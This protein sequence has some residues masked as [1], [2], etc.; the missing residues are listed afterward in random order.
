MPKIPGY[1]QDLQ[2]EIR[3]PYETADASVGKIR[4]Q[5]IQNFA[6]GLQDLGQGLQRQEAFDEAKRKEAENV[7]LATFGSAAKGLSDEIAF[8]ASSK[9]NPDGND[10]VKLYSDEY[11]KKMTAEM[12]NIKD[13]LTQQKAYT[14]YQEIKNDRLEKLRA[15]SERMFKDN[16][17][18]TYENQMK[19]GVSRV[20][21]NP[22]LIDKELEDYANTLMKSGYSQENKLKAFNLGKEQMTS[23]AL[24][25]YI[26]SGD[27][28]GAK[29]ALQNKFVG[30]FDAEKNQAWIDKIDNERIKSIDSSIKSA[31]REEKNFADALSQRQ[32]MNFRS[33]YGEISDLSKVDPYAPGKGQSAEKIITK[34]DDMVSSGDLKA[35]EAE[36]LKRFLSNDKSEDSAAVSLDFY[37]KLASGA[38]PDSLRKD[39]L[40]ASTANQISPQTAQT[41]LGR[42]ENE[43]QKQAAK[44]RASR[45]R[46]QDPLKKE[47]SDLIGAYF[48]PNPVLGGRDASSLQESE[49]D[50]KAAWYKIME[51]PKY[52]NDPVGAAR[53][54]LQMKVPGYVPATFKNEKE[55]IDL[56]K[57]LKTQYSSGQISKT[58]YAS[59]IQDLAKKRRDFMLGGK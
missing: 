43:K 6:S 40:T 46:R 5:A 53:K 17:N 27:Y 54:A 32:D 4:S 49:A 19:V 16:A 12:K 44:G 30:V 7:Q 57:N 9:A 10:L 35:P 48:K 25:G 34:I 2:R 39:I 38:N 42:I 51:N 15:D 1:R 21:S 24:N 37:N 55:I 23:A 29:S 28:A 20:S 59:K 33:V 26:N 8:N 22:T 56:S 18:I 47:A 31:E 11:D 45:D 41:L 50:A 58:E 3:A 36:H 13:P 52:K 14:K